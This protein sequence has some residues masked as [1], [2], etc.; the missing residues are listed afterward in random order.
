MTLVFVPVDGGFWV[1]LAAETGWE[2]RPTT[3][4][5]RSA[6]SWDKFENLSGPSVGAPVTLVFV[7]VDGGFR[8][9]SQR[10]QVGKPVPRAD[11]EVHGLVGQI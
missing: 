9:H 10:R 11:T 6:A 3:Q 8:L 4:T 1:V 5:Q 7:P 2:T